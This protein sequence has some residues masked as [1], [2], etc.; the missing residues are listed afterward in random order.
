MPSKVSYYYEMGRRVRPLSAVPKLW[1]YLKYR[2][3]PKAATTSI[4]RYAP[5]IASLMLTRRCNL[6]CAY[7][8][9]GNL[10]NQPGAAWRRG[11]ATLEKIA[12]IFAN[13]LFAR[14]LLVDLLGG[15]PLLVSDLEEIVAYL[16]KRGHIVN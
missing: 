5:Q 10:I 2:C 16:V 7:C 15:E 8:S 3:L 14:C 9:A 1:N 13:P 6:A 4:R 12:R 11:E